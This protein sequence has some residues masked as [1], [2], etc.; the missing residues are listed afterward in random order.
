[1][2]IW[3]GAHAA[4]IDD[5][6]NFLGTGFTCADG[7][8]FTCA[9]VIGTRQTAIAAFDA[10]THVK[11]RL[12]QGGLFPR[13]AKT[14]CGEEDALCDV[15]IL[16][17]CDPLVTLPSGPPLAKGSTGLGTISVT[18]YYGVNGDRHRDTI[19]PELQGT[20][21]PGWLRAKPEN[22]AKDHATFGMSGAPAFAKGNGEAVVGMLSQGRGTEG[23]GMALLVPAEAL[24]RALAMVKG[25]P[26]AALGLWLD[27]TSA[28]DSNRR[29][30][31]CYLHAPSQEARPNQP[32]RVQFAAS[33]GDPPVDDG[34][35]LTRVELH[36]SLPGELTAYPR[37]GESGDL[38]LEGGLVLRARG[39]RKK[40]FWELKAATEE[41]LHGRN[42]A[43]EAQP[44]FEIAD[45]EAGQT[46]GLRMVAFANKD[47]RP[48]GKALPKDLSRARL[49]IISRLRLK[50]IMEGEPDE[51]GAILLYASDNQVKEVKA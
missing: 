18:G 12:V 51:D 44:L 42:A 29:Y 30:A 25:E 37:L 17:P 33:F 49:A 32:L 21:G 48:G 19:Y 4:L 15:A 20:D 1:M 7:F 47:F 43:T 38:A 13:K 2:S 3:E 34:P 8:L 40:P 22:A 24:A 31:A 27:E 46:V 39:S 23:R 6:G 41:T 14:L 28:L 5:G 11:L 26:V 50:T 35:I 36:V 10:S 9:H 45:A 16:C